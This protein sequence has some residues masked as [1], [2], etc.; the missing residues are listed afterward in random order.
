METVPR[1]GWPAG[2][3]EKSAILP[4]AVMRNFLVQTRNRVYF[5]D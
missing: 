1:P 5:A 2:R 3:T 4:P